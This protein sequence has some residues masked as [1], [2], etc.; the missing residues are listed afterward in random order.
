MKLA[1]TAVTVAAALAV[2]AG[3]TA[4]AAMA[5]HA[6]A[7]I[8][9]PVVT[10]KTSN[11]G[12]IVATTKKLGLY[13]WDTEKDFKVHCTSACAKQWP[14]VLLMKGEKVKA[15]VHGLMGEFGTITRPDGST[16]L[17]WNKQP[18]YTYVGDT[19]GV[20]KCDNTDG[21]HAVRAA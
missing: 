14:P 15:M 17:T 8:A 16:Q 6:A 20:V 1:R 9:P 13:V 4:S 21:W 19:P 11:L 2:A 7:P 10:I 3:S 5:A 18:A 12:P